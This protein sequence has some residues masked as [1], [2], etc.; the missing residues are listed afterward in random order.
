MRLDGTPLGFGAVAIRT[1][2]RL[3]DLLP[4][5]YATGAVCILVTQ[6]N[7]RLGDMAAGTIVARDRRPSPP[8]VD[9]TSGLDLASLPSWDA[10]SVN[11]EEMAL[12]RRFV[13]RRSLLNS[14]S[15]SQLAASIAGP[16]RGKVAAP[17]APD[18]DEAFLNRL[19][20]EKM[21]RQL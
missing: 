16:L 17:D 12:V 2:L 7:Q 19:Y 15:R 3:V 18:N 1:L 8:T 4:F 10:A 5:L 20:A 14:E 21:R 6:N 13:E 9:V 11:D